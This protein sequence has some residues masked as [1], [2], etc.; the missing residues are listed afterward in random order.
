MEA[1]TK[2][3]GFQNLS[4]DILKLLD[5]ESLMDCRMVNS[6]WKAI[7]DQPSFWLKKMNMS[8]MSKDAQ[9]SW[10][11]LAQKLDDIDDNICLTNK[12]TLRSLPVQ[13]RLK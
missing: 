7:L 4:E 6:S 10:K 9:N 2:T 12:F 8:D 11:M 3:P 13:T 1:I 5:K